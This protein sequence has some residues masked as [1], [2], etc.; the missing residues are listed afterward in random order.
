MK[1]DINTTIN[2]L[3]AFAEDN[4]MLDSLDATYCL[5]KLA[6]LADVKP[7]AK[8]EDYGDATFSELVEQFVAATNVDKK[9][10]TDIL[11]PL[12]HTVNYYFN[13][14]FV[15]N[16]DK[17]F[18]FVFDLYSQVGSV[19]GAA[20]GEDGGY[21]NYAAGGDGSGVYSVMIPVGGDQLKYTPLSVGAR[22]ATLECK[23]I[24]S[25]D[26]AAREAAF[27]EEYGMAIVKRMGDGDYYCAKKTALSG[28]AVKETLNDGVV[29][30]ALLDYAA[31]ALSLTGPK[32]STVREV[33]K[34]VKAAADK[35]LNFVLACEAGER[36][37]FYFVFANATEATEVFAAATPLS[38][39]GVFGTVELDALLSVLEKGTALSSDLFMFKSIYSSIGGVKHGAKARS[40]L[41]AELAKI[42]K[43][44]LAAAASCDE[45]AVRALAE[46]NN[47]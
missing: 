20:S 33:A 30:I 46:D 35:G 16:P 43:G 12:P 21:T 32:N 34:L 1:A 2:K 6:R 45:A 18:D 38:A 47:G 24:M 31:P 7:V 14:E 39:C 5:N 19:T 22:V 44:M 17:A 8:E 40:V 3:V 36:T 27:A 15:R 10:V 23:D 28:A 41:D 29:K 25:E 26:I 37:K 42:Y 9:A 11:L 4:L 13:D